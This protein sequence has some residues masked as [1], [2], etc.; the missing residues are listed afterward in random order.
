MMRSPTQ[1]STVK[2]SLYNQSSPLQ[3]D[4][5]PLCHSYSWAEIK[6]FSDK[7]PQTPEHAQVSSYFLLSWKNSVSVATFYI[8]L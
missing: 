1:E 5:K 6:W 3:G 4:P 7:I 8:N 2:R